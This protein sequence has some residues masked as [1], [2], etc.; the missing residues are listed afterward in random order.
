MQN[1]VHNKPV[2]DMDLKDAAEQ[3]N[4]CRN[5]LFAFL[6]KHNV[7]DWSLMPWPAL[8]EVV[9]VLTFGEQKYNPNGGNP[10]NWR[11]VE[12]WDKRY[13]SASIRH[14]LAWMEGDTLDTETGCNHLAHAACCI[15]FML[16]KD[17][18][19]DYGADS[20]KAATLEHYQA[21]MIGFFGV[22]TQQPAAHASLSSLSD[23]PAALP[24]STGHTQHWS[25]RYAT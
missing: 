21:Q 10:A 8:S 4:V 20:E 23:K 12:G 24:Y 17:M 22:C 16:S 19:H 1:S 9:H 13:F 5:G 6:R 11:H 25:T 18:E 7:H 3:L 15:L 2:N 14:L